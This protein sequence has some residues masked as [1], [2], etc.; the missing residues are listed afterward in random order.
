MKAWHP[1]YTHAGAEPAAAAPALPEIVP[2]RQ[3]CAALDPRS[4]S[5]AARFKARHVRRRGQLRGAAALRD[6]PAGSSWCT[7]RLGL[8]E[9]QAHQGWNSTSLQFS[10]ASARLGPGP[11]PT[12]PHPATPPVHR[13]ARY[14]EE[15][16]AAWA[17]GLDDVSDRLSGLVAG[18]D[19][20]SSL[21]EE[22]QAWWLDDMRA[23]ADRVTSIDGH[24]TEAMGMRGAFPQLAGAPLADGA[25]WGAAF[26][27]VAP[28]AATLDAVAASN[29]RLERAGA[30]GERARVG[31]ASL[32]RL[33][34]GLCN[35]EM[36]A[37][38]LTTS[39]T[40]ARVLFA[41]LLWRNTISIAA[42]PATTSSTT[43]AWRRGY[44]STI[45]AQPP[46]R[47]KLTVAINH[48]FITSFLFCFCA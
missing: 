39:C 43:S 33:D 37:H 12:E 36:L 47:A 30:H 4:S 46:L 38:D 41:C 32:S 9:R 13:T 16:E 5:Y 26:A 22:G 6:H 23:W 10:S 34:R 29:A 11:A 35:E 19:E 15:Q 8:L 42:C 1:V 45:L 27:S 44:V 40:G 48:T 17:A 14:T 18:T 21:P 20:L 24:G 7:S 31:A 25:A 28:A 3:P 2:R